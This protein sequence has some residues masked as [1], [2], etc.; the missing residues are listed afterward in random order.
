MTTSEEKGSKKRTREAIKEEEI[1][2]SK[3]LSQEFIEA[4]T[5]EFIEG[6]KFILEKDPSLFDVLTSGN[7]INFEIDKKGDEITDTEM[8]VENFFHR[9][10][11]VIIAQQISNKA[12]LSIKQKYLDIFDNEKPTIKTV[13]E[14]FH[15]EDGNEFKSQI[16]AAGFSG[17][18]LS[19]FESLTDYFFE[20]KTEIENLFFINKADD[21]IIIDHLVTNIKGIGPWSAKMFLTMDLKRPNVFAADDLGVAR[22][23]SLYFERRP[24]ILKDLTSKRTQKIKSK[25]NKAKRPTF[26]VYDHDLVE[27]CGELFAPHRTVFMYLLWRLSSTRV[28]AMTKK[29]IRIDPIY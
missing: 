4:H 19:Y 20:K 15:G 7:F 29:R 24:D 27:S 13:Y 8:R 5:P 2:D 1:V 14:R 22:G 28:D 6:C 11:F 12:S 10:T 17:R 21:D 16:R 18:K 23:C 25:F 9:L 3:A 26:K